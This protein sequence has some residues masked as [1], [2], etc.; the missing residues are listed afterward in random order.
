MYG[1][2]LLIAG[3]LAFSPTTDIRYEQYNVGK[4]NNASL[5]V[6]TP[7]SCRFFDVYSRFDNGD[8]ENC[9]TNIATSHQLTEFFQDTGIVVHTQ[10]EGGKVIITLKKRLR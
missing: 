7:K 6:C 4:S 1:F 5:M 10:C 9:E 8:L 2:L 3:F